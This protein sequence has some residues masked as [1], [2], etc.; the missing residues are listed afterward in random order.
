MVNKIINSWHFTSIETRVTLA[1][2]FTAVHKLN[3]RRLSATHF[4]KGFSV[5]Q[6]RSWHWM[7]LK[8]LEPLTHLVLFTKTTHLSF[9]CYN[10][11]NN[12][13]RVL[14]SVLYIFSSQLCFA[15]KANRGTSFIRRV[16][17]QEKAPA[18]RKTAKLIPL[19]LLSPVVNRT[20]RAGCFWESERREPL[21]LRIPSK[22]HR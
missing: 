5:T 4:V 2:K 10:C 9:W 12:K 21:K 3:Q 17:S 20:Q 11:S 22:Q 6:C 14:I 19:L 18:K 8:A 16:S 7:D 1:F 15:L 13:G